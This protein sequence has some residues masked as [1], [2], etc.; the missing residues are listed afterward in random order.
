MTN[1]KQGLTRS[2]VPS[3]KLGKHALAGA[4]AKK[5]TSGDGDST[6]GGSVG[7][8]SSSTSRGRTSF[9][10]LGRGRNIAKDANVV[11]L[12]DAIEVEGPMSPYSIVK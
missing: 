9:L 2:V 5:L 6:H 11:A 12:P 7:T 1:N 10:H 3:K 4:V 8:T